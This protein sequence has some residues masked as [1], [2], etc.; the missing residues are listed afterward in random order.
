VLA[1]WKDIANYLHRDVRTVQRWEQSRGL[2][3][4]RLPGYGKNAIYALKSELDCWW[5]D[6]PAQREKLDV[7]A[8]PAPR[9]RRR[10]YA[11]WAAVSVLTAL[12]LSIWMLV[13]PAAAP[14]PLRLE[15]LT[16]L[17]GAELYPSLSPDGQRL[18]F[19]W[20][21]PAQDRFDLYLMRLPAG[22]PEQLT[23][24]PGL[25]L[26]SEWS[27][28]GSRLAYARI[29][30]GAGRLEVR[31]VDAGTREDTLLFVEPL[32][33]VAPPP[34]AIAWSR[35]GDALILC[36]AGADDQRF[37][38]TR[39]E[40]A[41]GKRTRLTAPDRPG[42]SDMLPAISPD[43]SSV[44]F[45]R[46][47]IAGDGN[48]FRQ[49]LNPDD[50]PRGVA[51]Q[52]THEECCV[53]SPSWSVDGKEVIFLSRRGGTPRLM[54][55]DAEGGAARQDSRVSRPGSAPRVAGNGW[56]LSWDL[57]PTN[58]VLE[59]PLRKGVAA[60]PARELIVSSRRDGSPA[61]SPD[62]KQIVFRSD[63]SGVWQLWVYRRSDGTVRQLTRLEGMEPFCPDW[64]RDGKWVAFEG[65]AGKTIG[66]CL[67]DVVTGRHWR[68]TPEGIT[69]RLPRWSRIGTSLYIASDRTGR[70]ETWRIYIDRNGQAV[71]TR[72]VTAQGGF[73]GVES[74]DGQFIYYSKEMTLKSIWRIPAG[75]GKEEEVLKDFPFNRYPTNLAAG[76]DGLYFRGQG[77]EHGEQ[78]QPI[79][80]L[81]FAGGSPR[82][83]MVEP[84]APSPGGIAVSP[85]GHALLLSGV[86]YQVGDVLAYK[87][88]R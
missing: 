39:H 1:C 60:G 88:F 26:F 23:R 8:V 10:V 4:H 74:A 51:R 27:P 21:P 72:Q 15:L 47:K 2:P 11:F 78:G 52:I 14:L 84:G 32:A 36:T 28:D 86:S 50:S 35:R 25:H 29:V 3:V 56:L 46:R 70:N 6:A 40:I 12:S 82:K 9:T 41:S 71:R 13:K 54:R 16:S 18:L 69:G 42:F 85:D 20:Q 59:V 79:W 30:V 73:S 49:D 31:L 43:G 67:A 61:F 19:T 64:S 83:V 65:H 34:W 68:V 81:S 37:G 77:G 75:G 38:L 22:T 87:S 7:V 55:V 62:A 57:D 58:R 44:V 66:V 76:P 53:D 45:L 80:M 63:R 5:A 17:P 24:S 48:L 33:A